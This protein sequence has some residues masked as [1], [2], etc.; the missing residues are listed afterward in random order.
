[1]F[2]LPEVGG[3][4]LSYQV[5]LLTIEGMAAFLQQP[6]VRITQGKMQYGAIQRKEYQ[7]FVEFLT[8]WVMVKSGYH[9]A[10]LPRFAVARALFEGSLHPL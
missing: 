4:P 1:M 8:K 6:G 10:T 2:K 7:N 9:H 5:T 3:L